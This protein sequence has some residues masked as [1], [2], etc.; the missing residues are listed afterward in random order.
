MNAPVMRYP[1]LHLSLV[2]VVLMMSACEAPPNELTTAVLR[3]SAGLTIAD[4]PA[5]DGSGQWRLDT[6]P[7]LDIGGDTGDDDLFGVVGAVRL[8]DGRIVVADGA[9]RIL[10][11]D[12][13]GRRIATVGRRG[14]GP[15]EF[16]GLGWLQL[17]P[18]DSLMAYDTRLRRALVYSPSLIFARMITPEPTNVGLGGIPEL[19]GAFQDGTLLARARLLA[20]RLASGSGI[21]RPDN[22]LLLY[23][24]TGSLRDSIGVI[25]GD[26]V[27][28]MQGIIAQPRF[29][30]KTIVAVGPSAFHVAPGERFEVAVHRADGGISRIIRKAHS[31]EPVTDADREELRAAGGPDIPSPTSFP[32]LTDM[33][34]DDEGVLWVQEFSR[35]PDSSARWDTFDSQGRLLGVVDMIPRFRPLHVG[36]DFVLGVWR[37]D[38]DVE[39]VRFHRLYRDSD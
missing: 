2:P 17:L 36:R 20:G 30:R 27:A 26:E 10:A 3:D 33:L 35:D 29:A 21:V 9:Q 39:H 1:W 7:A 38:M 22:V 12:S 5:T 31:P 8:T 14:S 24:A 13:T 28:I 25:P 34:L 32:A 19:I 16:E 6:V 23:D 18:G 4:N 15:E 11:F 37:D